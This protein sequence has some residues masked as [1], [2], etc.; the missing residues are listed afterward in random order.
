MDFV[1]ISSLNSKPAVE[2]NPIKGFKPVSANEIN[3]LNITNEGLIMGKSPYNERIQF[4]DYVIKEAKRLIKA[5][6]DTPTKT[7]IEQYCD[8]Y[9]LLQQIKRDAN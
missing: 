2:G 8:R 3:F 5:H 9:A 1:S 4:I 6:G 7:S